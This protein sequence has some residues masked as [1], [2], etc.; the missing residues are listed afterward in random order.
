MGLYSSSTRSGHLPEVLVVDDD[1]DIRTVVGEAL[2]RAGFEV[3]TAESAGRA[4]E[5]IEGRGLPSLAVID[6]G[7]PK[8]SGLE[9]ARSIKEFS[10]LPI[11]MLTAVSDSGTMVTALDEFA[12]DY[13]TKP[14]LLPVLVAR[15]RRVLSRIQDGSPS[16]GP[17]VRVDDRLTVELTRHRVLIDGEPVSLTP[18]ESKLMHI[19]LR[20]AG[21]TVR[22]EFLLSRVW[23]LEEVYDETLR[24]H[25]YRLRRKIEKDPS[26]PRYIRTVRGQGYSFGC[27]SSADRP[28]R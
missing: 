11:V 16:H 22:T 20:D 7:L 28:E 26:N 3:W 6:I 27:Q 12:E 15:V 9:L 19:L 24:V 1:A 4:L 10:D 18:I 23:P 21:R 2:S 17:S 13:V 25:V 14:V 8:T 5:L